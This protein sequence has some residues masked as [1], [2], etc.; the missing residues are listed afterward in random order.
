M[1]KDINHSYTDK[2]I[3]SGL[4]VILC[5]PAVRRSGDRCRPLAISDTL[6][7]LEFVEFS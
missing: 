4:F 6:D 3:Y 1:K 5:R 2:V 7:F